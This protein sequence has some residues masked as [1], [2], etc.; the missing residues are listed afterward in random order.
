MIDTKGALIPTII[1]VIILAIL[2]VG[3]IIDNKGPRRGAF[4]FELISSSAD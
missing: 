3:L 4:S 2:I 1:T